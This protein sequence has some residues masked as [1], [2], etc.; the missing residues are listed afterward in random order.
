MADACTQALSAGVAVG[1]TLPRARRRVPG[2]IV[3]PEEE[4]NPLRLSARFRDI[5]ARL[6]PVVEPIG[7]DAVLLDVSGVPVSERLDA[8]DGAYELLPTAERQPLRWAVATSRWS[9]R[10]A[11]ESGGV[12]ASAPAV[13]LWP[14]D[15]GIGARLVRLGAFTCGQVAALGEN[16]LVY[17]LGRRTGRPLWRR[18]CGVDTDP[19][20]PLWPP[21]VVDVSR[22]CSLDPLE[23]SASVDACLVLLVHEAGSQLGAIRRHAR[24]VA[25]RIATEAG[26]RDAQWRVPL[27]LGTVS[28]LST[29][30]AR[31]RAQ[32]TVDSPVTGLRL[33]CHELDLAPAR[34]LSLFDGD[35][36]ADG[37]L[38]LGRVRLL[39]SE[40]YG[41]S[42]LR[43][44]ADIPLS[45][46]DRRRALRVAAGNGPFE[47][48]WKT[49]AVA[50]GG[51]T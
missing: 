23:N 26:L 33:C 42:S 38:A 29:A 14:E 48:P 27:P 17:A 13:E 46:R 25:L 34:E 20:R 21:P 36:A 31:L 40:R 22:D 47:S 32:I 49:G 5:F 24:R 50:A 3:V 28:D 10:L 16:A 7:A 1:M 37:E 6:S 43:R 30:V 9:A 45:R 19:L 8:I 12:F 4:T 18:A 51:L 35:R 41:N 44:L 2:L 11:A 39:M 15:P